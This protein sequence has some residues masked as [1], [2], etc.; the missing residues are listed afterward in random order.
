M[1]HTWSCPQMKRRCLGPQ[2][3][4]KDEAARKRLRSWKGRKHCRL[5]LLQQRE[6]SSLPEARELDLSGHTSIPGSHLDTM[7]HTSSLGKPQH[8][9]LRA[10]KRS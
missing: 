6:A 2:G 8:F 4:R 3:P 5:H 10:R 1:L 9:S 7:A